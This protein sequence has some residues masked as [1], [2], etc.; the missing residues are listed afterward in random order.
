MKLKFCI[1]KNS[2][3]SYFLPAFWLK[4][5]QFKFIRV[6]HLEIDDLKLFLF[7]FFLF[8]YLIQNS[9]SSSK[10]QKS[11]LLVRKYGSQVRVHCWG[12]FIFGLVLG[13]NML[14]YFWAYRKAYSWAAAAAG[15][16]FLPAGQCLVS[17]S[18]LSQ[19]MGRTRRTGVEDALQ[20]PTL[21]SASA[22]GTGPPS[23]NSDSLQVT[24]WWS[25]SCSIN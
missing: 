3:E 14:N 12:F 23:R 5:G 21:L 19:G 22:Q 10:V 1:L 7:A 6:G 9:C 20:H 15:G 2:R 18:C 13:K 11:A 17:Q 16:A 8:F 4:I 25:F 24:V